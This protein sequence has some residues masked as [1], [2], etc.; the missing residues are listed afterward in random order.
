MVRITHPE[1]G[2]MW[3]SGL[4]AHFSRTP[5]PDVRA[6]PLQGE[7]SFAV[8]EQLLGM[9]RATYERLV[10]LEVTGKGPATGSTVENQ[11]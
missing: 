5:A 9:D 6:A 3:Q 8:F 7:H 10:S 4:A 1:A 11:A 2:E